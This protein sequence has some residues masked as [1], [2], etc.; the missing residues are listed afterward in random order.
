MKQKI[1]L[2]ILF[3]FLMVLSLHAQQR[4]I[5]GKVL[6]RASN[7]ALPNVSILEKTSGNGV[8]SDSEGNF[9]INVSEKAVLVFS[10]IG[11][12]TQEISVGNQSTIEVSLA[13]SNRII[14]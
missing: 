1:L 4:P 3:P 6:D 2:T 8:V 7:T 12:E 5:K 13:E 14:R 9:G 11:Y 10:F